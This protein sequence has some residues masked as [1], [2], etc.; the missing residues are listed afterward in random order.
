MFRDVSDEEQG[1][2]GEPT[3]GVVSLASH[4]CFENRLTAEVT[5]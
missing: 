2:G 1:I 4:D 5:D 3:F